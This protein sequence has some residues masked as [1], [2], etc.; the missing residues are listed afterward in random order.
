MDAGP[1]TSTGGFTDDRS[2]ETSTLEGLGEI[3]DQTELEDDILGNID[4][5]MSARERIDQDKRLQNIAEELKQ[6]KLRI[7][8][9]D[10]H[11]NSVK[12][13]NSLTKSVRKNIQMIKREK[14]NR[15]KQVKKLEAKLRSLKIYLGHEDIPNSED[16]DDEI[17]HQLQ[18]LLGDEETEHDKKIKNGEMTPFGTFR[19]LKLPDVDLFDQFLDE[20]IGNGKKQ[21]RK[22]LSKCEP[23]LPKQTLMTA[24]K[25]EKRSAEVGTD[26]T[27]LRPRKKK[28]LTGALGSATEYVRERRLRLDDVSREEGSQS[29]RAEDH[30]QSID[31][32][33]YDPQKEPESSAESDVVCDDDDDDDGFDEHIGKRFKQGCYDDGDSKMYEARLRGLSEDSDCSDEDVDEDFRMPTSLWNK[34]YKY[35]QTCVKW[36]WELHQFKCGGII[37]DEMGL[38]KT[39]QAIAFLRGLRHSNTKLPGEAFR[40]LGPIIL[41]TPATVMHQWVKEFHKWFP[42]QRV[43]VLHNSGSYSGRKK[44]TLIDEIHSS[45]GTLI[46]SYQ[47]IVMYQDDLIHHHW[48]YIILDEGHKIR[49][50]DAQATLAV[51]QFR[52]PHRLILSGSPIQNNLRE[53]W[54]LFDFVFPGKLGTL[55]VFMAE[56]AVPITHGGYANATETQVAVGY[57]CATILRDTIK[58]YLLRRMK[59]DVKTSINLPPKSEQVIFCKLTERQRDL[60]R[61]YVE[62]HEVKKILDGR[63]Q[64]FVGLVNL[65]KI[66]NHPDLYDGGPDKD[67]ITSSR[68]PGSSF[69]FYKR[70]GKLMVVEALLKLWSKQKQRVLLF[71]Q[72]RQML[73]ILEEFVQNRHYTYLSMDGSTAISTRQPAI[74]RFNQDSSIFIFLLTTRVGGLGVNLTGAN[75]VIIYDPDWNP[76]TDMQARERAWRIGQQKDVTVYRLMTAGTIE[77]KIYHR[78]IFKQFL[79][80]R[81]LKNPKQR[82]FFKTN[83]MYELFTLSEDVHKEERTET[84]DIFAGTGSTVDRKRLKALNK[85]KRQ[86]EETRRQRMRELAKKLSQKIGSGEKIVAAD[87]DRG[88]EVNTVRVDGVEIEG[89]ARKSRYKD[90]SID[91]QGDASRAN[92]DYILAKLFKNSKV[93]S[94]MKHDKIMESAVPDGSLVESE[95]NHVAQEAIKKLK[96]ARRLCYSASD[97]VPNW[98]GRHGGFRGK[99]KVLFGTK[100][101]KNL[102]ASTL[103]KDAKKDKTMTGSRKKKDASLFNYNPEKLNSQKVASSADLMKQL[104][105][106]TICDADIEKISDDEGQ[107]SS[108]ASGAS[109][110][111]ESLSISGVDRLLADIRTFIAIESDVNGQATTSEIVSRFRETVSKDK[112]TLF[113]SLLKKLCEFHRENQGVWKLRPEFR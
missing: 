70:S 8:I 105:T 78:Q 95:A 33:D 34:L 27:L 40:G 104:R 28:R 59:S 64:I 60:Y 102:P 49:N 38:G 61:E 103:P 62:S 74:D 80:N 24:A 111:K 31:D 68:K 91:D 32:S 93:H 73:R 17:R 15:E 44:S 41:V 26:F 96:E 5:Q 82:R 72:S 101:L 58:P 16:V 23:S 77:E 86:D 75:R 29:P 69:G 110:R 21:Q 22:K 107:G 112:A 90:D 18:M 19:A 1:S 100:V 63:M 87:F 94:V 53:L 6:T 71:T 79:T 42:R 25:A 35:Q 84:S 20:E 39:I 98:T 37:G 85:Q 51:K 9:I 57:R 92:N 56:F 66:C 3:Y 113:K 14:E 52:T 2:G 108:A 88:H 11:L 43:G 13:E 106:R 99:K 48:H 7:K 45:K 67:I 30:D 47:G 83:E 10:D 97:G 50:P 65:R 46:T 36:L 12:D 89:A 81:V 76:S 109:Q 4:E 55:P 54:S